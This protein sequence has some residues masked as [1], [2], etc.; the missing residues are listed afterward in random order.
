MKRMKRGAG[1]EKLSEVKGHVEAHSN[2][3]EA[4]F[5][6]SMKRTKRGTGREEPMKPGGDEAT[7]TQ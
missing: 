3:D 4:T 5:N 1:R 7:F 2:N 6:Y